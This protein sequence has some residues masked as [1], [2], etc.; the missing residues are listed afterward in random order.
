MKTKPDSMTVQDLRGIVTRIRK[1]QPVIDQLLHR[2]HSAAD[3]YLAEIV[4]QGHDLLAAKARVKFGDWMDYVATNIPE[5]SHSTANNYMRIAAHWQHSQSIGA[6]SQRQALL[7][8]AGL[9]GQEIKLESPK[10]SWVPYIE[11]LGRANKLVGYVEKNPL[12]QWP[13]EGIEQLRED[14]EPLAGDLW[15]G[16][17]E[18]RKQVRNE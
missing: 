14:L 18:W 8:C 1:R 17:N 7:L 16:F 15:P 13:A 5:M 10:R 3:E 4:L 2:V 6:S 11:G 12:T 9:E